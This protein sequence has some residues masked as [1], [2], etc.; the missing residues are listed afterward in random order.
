MYKILRVC[1]ALVEENH[2]LSIDVKPCLSEFGDHWA[3][4]LHI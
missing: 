4:L 2:L 3:Q 1:Q